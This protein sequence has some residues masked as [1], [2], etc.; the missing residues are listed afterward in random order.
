[1]VR[2]RTIQ[3][4][5]VWCVHVAIDVCMLQAKNRHFLSHFHGYA[6]HFFWKNGRTWRIVSVANDVVELINDPNYYIFTCVTDLNGIQY[7]TASKLSWMELRKRA[8]ISTSNTTHTVSN[9]GD[10]SDRVRVW[11]LDAI[12]VAVILWSSPHLGFSDIIKRQSALFESPLQLPPSLV[13][14]A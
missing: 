8:I 12:M 5:V 6:L 7:S 4:A 2:C 1:M 3:K 11:E 13:G 14:G 9:R 10:G